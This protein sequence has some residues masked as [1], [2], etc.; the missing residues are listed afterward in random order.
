MNFQKAKFNQFFFKMKKFIIFLIILAAECTII[1]ISP[2]ICTNN[3]DGSETSPFKTI[4]EGVSLL[5]PQ[6]G[7]ELVL[8]PGKYES[9]SDFGLNITNK[10]YFIY[11][12]APNTVTIDCGSENFGLR[13]YN[14]KYKIAN[15]SFNNCKPP[16]SLTNQIDKNGGALLFYKSQIELTSLTFTKNSV[17]PTFN[18]G[19]IAF[20]FG[21]GIINN[22]RFLQNNNA[23]LGGALYMEK[24]SIDIQ[25]SIVINDNIASKSGGGLFANYSSIKINGGN[26]TGNYIQNSSSQKLQSQIGCYFSD[27]NISQNVSYGNEV[28]CTNCTIIADNKNICFRSSFRGLLQF[29]YVLI[30]I[31]VS[32]F[33]YI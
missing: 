27:F 15:L 29:T 17:P 28:S 8:L 33:Y 20:M 11:S 32:V 13:F 7:G 14:G 1:Y 5:N 6:G 31:S 19:A 23:L 12:K 22:C 26:I 25:D 16:L 2:S 4:L 3:C 10:E 9:N 18:G 30:F 24:A 21:S